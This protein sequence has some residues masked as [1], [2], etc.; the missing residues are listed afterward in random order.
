MLDE[1]SLE[2][3]MRNASRARLQ[4]FTPALLEAMK[5]FDIDD[6]LRRAAAFIAQ[7]AHES[8]EFRFMEENWGPTAAQDRYEPV[9]DLAKR[10]GNTEAGD[11]KRFKGRG[12]IQV[13]GRANYRKY[14]ELLGLDLVAQPELAATPETGF[15]V[16]GLFWQRNGLNALADQ[17]D[18]KEITRRINGGFN[19]LAE[20]QKFYDRALAVLASQFPAMAP[21]QAAPVQEP[22]Q[23]F[24]RGMEHAGREIKPRAVAKPVDRTLDARPDTTD[25]RDTMYVPTLTEVPTHIPLGDY[26]DYDVPILDQGREGACTGYGLAT[27]ANYLQLRRRVIPDKVPVSPRMLYTMARRYD[28]WPG[29]DYEGS[30]A[31]GAMKGWHKHGVCRE[32]LYPSSGKDDG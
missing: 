15:A 10:L 4:Q 25:F 5:R 26:L 11:G 6:N 30:S 8:G 12:P 9:S 18:F 14:G 21:P 1:R 28:E 13:T 23:P 29:E 16:A 20:R 27:V 24:E 2:Q 31:R 32:D 19:G 3:I 7:L 17:G 22:W